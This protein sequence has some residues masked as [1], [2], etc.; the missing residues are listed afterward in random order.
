M[1]LAWLAHLRF[2]DS[3]GFWTALMASWLL[4]LPEYDGF[5]PFGVRRGVRGARLVFCA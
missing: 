3:I 1:A 5:L 4:V 2:R